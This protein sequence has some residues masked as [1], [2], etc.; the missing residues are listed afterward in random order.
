MWVPCLDAPFLHSPQCLIY[1]TDAADARLIGVEYVVAESVFASL[2]SE[3]KQLW[4]SHEYEVR[5]SS[6][7]GKKKAPRKEARKGASMTGHEQTAPAEVAIRGWKVGILTS[8]NSTV[9][10]SSTGVLRPK[11]KPRSGPLCR[12]CDTSHLSAGLR[13]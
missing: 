11:A 4:H 10:K 1:D 2:P 5:G 6:Q 8:V 13:A 9:E 7:A 3:E 12:F